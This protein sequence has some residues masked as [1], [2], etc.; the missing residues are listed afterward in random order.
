M[1]II[2]S[3]PNELLRLAVDDDEVCVADGED[4]I[5]VTEPFLCQIK[6][7]I[8]A[9]DQAIYRRKCRANV[10]IKKKGERNKRG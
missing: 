9:T 7:G 6:D 8:N 5:D 10:Q 3:A 2:P 1:Y 4:D